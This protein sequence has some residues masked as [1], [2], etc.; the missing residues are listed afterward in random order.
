MSYLTEVI[1]FSVTYGA[2]L[3]YVQSTVGHSRRSSAATAYVEPVL[4]R[5]NLDVLIQT[6]VLK[7]I[8]TGQSGGQP[9]FGEVEVAQDASSR[10]HN[11]NNI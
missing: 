4:D 1:P 8:Q 3:G 6:Q 10:C 11:N 2:D 9:V 7:L 5:A